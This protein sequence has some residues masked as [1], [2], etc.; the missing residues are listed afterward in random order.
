MGLHPL[1][2]VMTEEM[3]TLRSVEEA[4]EI[5][6]RWLWMA[7]APE[8]VADAN[9][10]QEIEEASG[11]LKCTRCKDFVEELL[12]DASECQ[13]CFNELVMEAEPLSEEVV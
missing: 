12:G 4:W 3:W 6:S 7:T 13:V 9:L 8:T 5:A 1:T 2:K 11:M 10:L